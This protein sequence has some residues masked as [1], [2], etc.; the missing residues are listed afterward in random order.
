MKMVIENVRVQLPEGVATTAQQDRP[1]E[2]LF[3]GGKI[4]AQ[5]PKRVSGEFASLT[6]TCE[7]VPL[8]KQYQGRGYVG[9][10]I[11]FGEIVEATPAKK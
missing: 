10:E 7:V 9:D 2:V 8:A 11:R 5:N 3:L 1:S 6:V 4:R